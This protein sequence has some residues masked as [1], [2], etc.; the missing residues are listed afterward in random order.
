[1]SLSIENISKLKSTKNRFRVSIV[2]Y[3]RN[4]TLLFL[5]ELESPILPPYPLSFTFNKK[6]K[7]SIQY[8]KFNEVFLIFPLEELFVS[9]GPILFNNQNY[10]KKDD[11][12]QPTFHAGY[13]EQL[14][15]LSSE[16]FR[17]LLV[18]IDCL[19]ELQLEQ[20][21]ATY[22]QLL[23][24]V[25][26]Q[27]AE[28]FKQP[29]QKDILTSYA[30]LFHLEHQLME[31]MAKGDPTQLH[32]LVRQT[33]LG[34]LPIP[35]TNDLRGEK[36]YCII[37]MEKISWFAIHMGVDVI[38]CLSLRDY[39]IQEIEKQTQVINVLT[40][41]DS[42][43][44]Y[45]TELLHE[46]SMHSY[47]L[48]IRRVIQY[49]NA[50]IYEPLPLV[51]IEKHLFISNAQLRRSFKKEVGISIG[52]YIQEQKIIVAK[53]LLMSQI[54]PRTVAKDLHF[55]DASHFTKA[56]KKLTGMTPLQFQKTN[57]FPQNHKGENA[58]D[59]G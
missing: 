44:V 36:N 33:P 46:I 32:Q 51:D 13:L 8:G 42:A 48:M 2:V 47:S 3:E 20:Y 34:S 21:Y 41:R 59:R 31:A 37:L 35:E 24:G 14:P 9:I 54:P 17:D 53:Y 27:T 4:G 58:E 28:K 11:R 16:K 10:S 25:Q 29:L 52:A 26:K 30:I 22:I 19:F 39:Y 12:K 1:M 56:F 18:I 45:F 40:I 50:H 15:V 38:K 55:Y 7:L 23:A 49:I 57:P 6:H 5:E 43:I